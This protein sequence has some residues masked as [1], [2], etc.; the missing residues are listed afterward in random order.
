LRPAANPAVKSAI[1]GKS[2]IYWK[3]ERVESI[4]A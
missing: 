1:A 2:C 3:R 4:S